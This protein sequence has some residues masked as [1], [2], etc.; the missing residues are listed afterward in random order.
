[1]SDEGFQQDSELDLLLLHSGK[2]R[3]VYEVD[4]DATAKERGRRR[5]ERKQKAVPFKDWWAAERGRVEARENMDVA[6]LAWDDSG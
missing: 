6:A 4:A 1:M 5:Q 2:V 3:D